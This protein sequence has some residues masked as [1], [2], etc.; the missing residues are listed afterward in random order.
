MIAE[1]Q[2]VV[3]GEYLPVVLG[4][5]NLEGLILSNNG[6]FYN[7]EINPSLTN[8]FATAAFRFGHS[9][10]QGLIQMFATD[11][12]GMMNEYSLHK[13]FESSD[14]VELNQGEGLENILN[15]LVNQPSQS[16]DKEVTSEVT[17]FLLPK[18]QEFGQDL[19]ARNIQRGR[20]HGL[21]GFCCYYKVYE[22]ENF[23]CTNGWSEMYNGFSLENW[24]LLQSIY[25]KPSDIDLFTGGL[26][27]EAQDD[28]LIGNVFNQMIGNFCSFH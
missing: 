27:Q 15:G 5:Q 14:M 23:D 18:G 4:D 1:W 28:S 25:E 21:P 9:M 10:I 17:N 19:V 7:P 11:N 24:A 16:C 2:S 12:S 6:S 3:Y 26:T 22:D 13:Q 20:D 8:E